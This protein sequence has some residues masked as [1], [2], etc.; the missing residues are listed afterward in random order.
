MSFGNV[1]NGR[2]HHKLLPPWWNET[3]SLNAL[4]FASWLT[5]TCTLERPADPY[6]TGLFSQPSFLQLH[7]CEHQVFLMYADTARYFP[8]HP[9][10]STWVMLPTQ[11]NILHIRAVQVESNLTSP[12]ARER[13]FCLAV[14]SWGRR[15]VN[16]ANKQHAVNNHTGKNRFQCAFA[17]NKLNLQP[18]AS[19]HFQIKIL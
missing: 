19:T 5:C 1:L 7:V 18:E 11:R 15:Q 2:S 4:G 12:R 3:N 14:Y 10:C 16:W 8:T 9:W 6:E 13:V 17:T